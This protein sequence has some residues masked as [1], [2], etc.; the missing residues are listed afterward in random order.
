MKN[1][2]T[3][4][5][6]SRPT[7][8]QL[9]ERSFRRRAVE[10]AIWGIPIVSFDTMRQAFLRYAKYGD[11]VYLS[12]AADWRFQVTTPNASSLYVYFNFNLK[13]GPMV[14]ELPAADGAGL[15][16]TLLNAW[17]T[18]LADVGPEGEDGG[19]G[20]KYLLLPP[21]SE[22]RP[23]GYLHV[24]CDTYNGYGLFRAIPKTQSESDLERAIE[25]IKEL[26]LHRLGATKNSFTQRFVDVSGKIFDGI[27]RFD[28]TFYD[29]LARMVDEEPVLTRDL[30]IMG[31]L[32]SI[33]IRKGKPFKPS[34]NQRS[35]LTDA[36]A[37]VHGGFMETAKNIE[38]Y[39]PGS[40]WGLHSP[41]EAQTHF[42][43]QTKDRMALDERAE[44]YYLACAPPRAL[45]AATFYL[46]CTRDSRGEPLL[47]GRL[48]RLRIPP[49]PPARQFWAVTTYDLATA[50]FILNSPSVG[51][52]SYN[53]RTEKN[54][55]DSIDVYFAPKPFLQQEANWIY[56]GMR[57]EW[58]AFFRFYGPRKAILE[59]TWILPNIERV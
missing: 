23:I 51:I 55:D 29:S 26:R 49:N 17:Q 52:D 3:L 45:G 38:P 35:A 7:L 43:F 24:P 42:S 58:F 19:D 34:A 31:Q 32:Y 2:L 6:P 9:A 16:G 22:D 11:I 59:K 8:T 4:M 44:T 36:I 50:G 10:A 18:P 33:G 54:S 39:W 14:L 56:T 1:L 28:D 57:G 5:H 15:F 53:D 27:T 48:Y 25:L 12:Q 21:D 40:Q 47:G 20:G 41:V 37:D 46:A 13:D 30:A